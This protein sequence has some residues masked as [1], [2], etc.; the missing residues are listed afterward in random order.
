[1]SRAAA[2][3]LAFV[4]FSVGIAL[5]AL[6]SETR[7]PKVPPRL[8]PPMTPVEGMAH[9]EQD[10]MMVALLA[11]ARETNGSALY[12]L[13]NAVFYW[14]LWQDR[15]KGAGAPSILELGPGENLGQGVMLVAMGAK[16]YTGLD[17]HR[18]EHLYDRHGYQAA[19]GLI[20]LA[21]PRGA[22]L[23][24]ADIFSVEGE[25]VVFNPARV[26]YLYPRQSY[27]IGLPD[28]SIDYVFSH[29]V[30][31]HISE[32]EKTVAAIA[33]VLRSGGLTAHHFDMRDHKDFSRPLEFLKVDAGT[34]AT[35]FDGSNAH[36]YLNRRR[37]SDFVKMFKDSGYRIVSAKPTQTIAVSEEM[38]RG[39][40]PD[41]HHYSLDDLSVVSALI[42][43]QKP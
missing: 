24:A 37:L 3:A 42:V 27:D 8:T 6:W 21:A 25:R 31:E 39:L 34:W 7:E 29:S 14:Q 30:F 18:P 35:R 41:F 26:E 12:N 5:G 22:Q 16:K 23:K 32:P 43:A 13:G 40:H 17:L 33:K 2:F 19:M 4:L 28:G 9:F 11:R 1:M 10:K 36:F 38:R 15:S 20:G